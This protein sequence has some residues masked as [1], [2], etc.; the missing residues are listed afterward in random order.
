M[1]NLNTRFMGI[2]IKNPIVV[3]ASYLVSDTDN[4]KRLEDAGAAAIVYKSLFEEQIQL[5]SAQLDDDLNEYNERNAEMLSIFPRVQ[6]AG[7]AEHLLNLRK[8]KESIKIPLIASL[9]A[10]YNETWV[11][12]AKQIEQTGVDGIELNFYAVPNNTEQTGAAIEA[13]QI[14]ILTQVLKAVKI[15]VNV[16][17]SSAY[18][19]SFNFIKELDKAGAKGFTLFNRFYQPD[20][21]INTLK[22]TAQHS[23]SQ[24]NESSLA[25]R[26]AG[27]LYGNINAS[28]TAN[29]GLFEGADIIKTI[30][31]GAHSAAIV[32]TIY[33]NKIEHISKILADIEKWML[34]KNFKTIDEFRGKLSKKNINDPFVYQRAQY[35]DLLLNSGE[36]FKHYSLR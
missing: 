24:P 32:S 18:T 7:S 4:L 20:I 23:L 14:E 31:A 25:F 29:G 8:A 16:K 28:I 3:G 17:L 35:I 2:E 13:Q 1:A 27:L 21:D 12:Y 19:N 5:E 36:A 34:E 26:Y 22:H 11:E 15:P 30:L 6:H 10:I 9:N 33:K